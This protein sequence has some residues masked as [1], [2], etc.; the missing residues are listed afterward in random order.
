M[1][2]NYFIKERLLAFGAKF[3]VYDENRNEA[4]LVEAD[5]FDIG[6]NINIYTP[7]KTSKLMYFR[8]QLRI[9]AH[10]YKVYDSNG[11]EISKIEKEFM[12]TR[13]NIS[14]S[15]GR[16]VMSCDSAILGRNYTVEKDG[17][18]IGEIN[19]EWTFGRDRYTLKVID[20]DYTVFLVGLLIMVDMVRFHSDN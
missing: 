3:D 7:D 2:K 10:K 4:F 20:E 8:Q 19:K 17:F 14:G 5:K 9:G 12:V 6:K 15:L 1:S 16:F 13:Y 18:K 11:M